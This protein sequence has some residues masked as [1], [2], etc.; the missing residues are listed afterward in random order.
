MRKFKRLLVTG[1]AG[2][3]GSNFVR[4]LSQYHPDIEVII[5]D[6]LTYAGNK[7]NLLDVLGSKIKLVI[8]DICDE[9]LVDSLIAD[10]DGII[11]FAAESHVDNSLINAAPFIDSNISGV[12][13]L[14]TSARKYGVYFHQVSTDEVFGD[15]PLNQVDKD[16]QPTKFDEFSPYKP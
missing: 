1:G 14:L 5:L 13:V 3:I 9:K 12:S 6:K 4:F 2:F 15:L 8:G 11:N 16:G 10:V 7:N